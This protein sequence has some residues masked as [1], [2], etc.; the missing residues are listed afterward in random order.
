MKN[1]VRLYVYAY[2]NHVEY[3]TSNKSEFI[4]YLDD[5]IIIDKD[6]LQNGYNSTISEISNC[7]LGVDKE[8][9]Q[10]KYI[11]TTIML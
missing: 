3:V 6:D 9:N 1:V 5:E 8:L 10:L 11:D 2:D 4:D 7:I